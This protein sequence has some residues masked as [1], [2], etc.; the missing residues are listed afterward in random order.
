[1]PFGI[2]GRVNAPPLPWR[3]SNVGNGYDRSA[4]PTFIAPSVGAIQE[5]PAPLR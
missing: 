1:M 5:S 4:V 2:G 3:K